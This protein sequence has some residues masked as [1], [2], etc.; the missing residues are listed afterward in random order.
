MVKNEKPTNT[1]DKKNEEPLLV[2][3]YVTW[4]KI[5]LWYFFFFI[6]MLT[7]VPITFC[8]A[9]RKFGHWGIFFQIPNLILII[10]AI[11]MTMFIALTKSIKIHKDRIV[12]EYLFFRDRVIDV[13]SLIITYTTGYAEWITFGEKGSSKWERILRVNIFVANLSYEGCLED[14]INTCKN[15]GVEFINKPGIGKGEVNHER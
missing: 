6:F 12:I 15:I 3:K 5:W 2:M 1:E 14:F 8:F 9:P 7:F 10:L 13:S 11:Y 4:K